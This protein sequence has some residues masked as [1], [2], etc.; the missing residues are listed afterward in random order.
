M[1]RI[2]TNCEEII[3]FDITESRNKYDIKLNI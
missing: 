3:L 2:M 1:K